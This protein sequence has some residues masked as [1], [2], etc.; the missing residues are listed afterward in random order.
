MKKTLILLALSVSSMF[1]SQITQAQ[2]V[3]KQK[4]YQVT[5]ISKD[6]TFSGELK[7]RLIKTFFEV[8]PKLAK[9]YNKKTSK[10]V[11]LLLIPLMMVWPLQAMIPLFSALNT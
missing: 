8:Y 10:K 3:F 5:F 2:E 11:T 6:A 9:E 4:G 1:T 7:D